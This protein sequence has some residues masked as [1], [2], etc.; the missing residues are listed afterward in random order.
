MDQEKILARLLEAASDKTSQ[1]RRSAICIE[2][3]LEVCKFENRPV[4]DGPETVRLEMIGALFQQTLDAR[5]DLLAYQMPMF[6]ELCGPRK[7]WGGCA[8]LEQ[9]IL[10]QL[11]QMLPDVSAPDLLAVDHQMWRHATT[12]DR[13]VFPLILGTVQDGCNRR[14]DLWSLVKATTELLSSGERNSTLFISQAAYAQAA[15][16]PQVLAASLPTFAMMTGERK[17]GRLTADIEPWVWT[18]IRPVS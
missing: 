9:R 18:V 4:N 3:Q 2:L 13:A 11:S 15:Q 14:T 6:A 8:V 7:F 16:L 17:P 5:P 10:D 1:D 12:P